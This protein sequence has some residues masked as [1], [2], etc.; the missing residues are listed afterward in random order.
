MML[1]FLI[2]LMVMVCVPLVSRNMFLPTQYLLYRKQS[3]YML[4]FFQTVQYL[5]ETFSINIIAGDF[6]NMIF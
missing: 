5:V 1:L 6:N 2:N 3:M 4:E